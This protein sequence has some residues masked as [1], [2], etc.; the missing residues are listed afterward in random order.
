MRCFVV[1]GSL[2]LLLSVCFSPVSLMADETDAPAVAKVGNIVITMLDV[3]LE[4]QKLI[5]MQM[6]FHSGLKK[7]KLQEISAEALDNL[8]ERAYKV[9]YAI[10][11]EIA[12]EPTVLENKWQL[13]KTSNASNLARVS[14]SRKEKLRADIYLHLLAK[15]AEKVAVEDKVEV[16]D[17]EVKAYYNAN[18]ENYLQPKLYKA[19]QI[20]IKVDPSSTTEEIES[21][22][23]KAT[24]L[25]QR[26]K[27]GEDFYNL[28]YYESD[29]R[30][31][32][33]GGSLGSFHAGQTVEEFDSALSK[34]KAGEISDL[35][36]TMYGFHIIKMDEIQQQRQLSYEEASGLIRASLEKQKRDKLYKEWMDSNKEK[37]PVN[38]Y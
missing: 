6:S 30:S 25:L 38:K 27:A 23:Q 24:I 11:E 3:Q 33:V 35:V 8:I 1:A 16:S 12:L 21:R 10:V 19:S 7:E 32:Y 18:R 29:D 17:N 37:F 9:Q 2:V 31:K 26:A 4:M 15:E 28:A 20:F 22:R 5:P 36:R 14:A 13:F 34:M